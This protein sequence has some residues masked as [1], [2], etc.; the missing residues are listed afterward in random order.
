VR[1][2]DAVLLPYGYLSQRH[3]LSARALVS[4]IGHINARPIT[5]YS[6]M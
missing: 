1:D 5:P 2:G 3:S 6:M 4:S